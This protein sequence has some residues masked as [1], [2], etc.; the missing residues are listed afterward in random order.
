MRM[1]TLIPAALATAAMAAPAG[2]VL[3]RYPDIGTAGTENPDTYAF[4][5]TGNGPLIGYYMGSTAAFDESLGLK[6]NGTVVADNIFANHGTPNFTA[7]DFGDVHA[8]DV[9]E[10]FI[11]VAQTGDVFSSDSARNVDGLN[12]VFASSY[13]GEPWVG[14]PAGTFLGFEDMKGGGDLNYND[15]TFVFTNLNATVVPPLS[16]VP[17]PASWAMMLA[18]FGLVGVLARMRR[19]GEAP[20]AA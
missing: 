19:R 3:F 18:G 2:A 6:V 14:M 4:T 11:T 10:F 5:A 20:I 1:F 7:F 16:P 15:L 12:H 8:G 9:L 13:A 17:E